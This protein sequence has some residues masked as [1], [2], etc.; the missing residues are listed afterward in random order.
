MFRRLYFLLPSVNLSQQVVN[1]LHALGIQD[2]Y[3]HAL[4][5]QGMPM[6]F[7]PVAT[8]EHKK[9]LAQHVENFIWKANIILFFVSMATLIY[10][11]VAGSL[12]Y[13]IISLSIMLMS[14]IAGDFYARY[15]P[16]A[17]I[18]DFKNAIQHNE[19]LIMVDVP[20]YRVAEIENCVHKH[21]PAAI[22]G[23]SSLSLQYIG[24]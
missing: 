6:Q 24:L 2:R 18:S 19:I 16:H 4:S 11:V 21:H 3:I 15:I 5:H 22:E 10:S 23:G 12:L 1:E 14:F 20:K 17:H 9:D 7:L 13:S 8:E